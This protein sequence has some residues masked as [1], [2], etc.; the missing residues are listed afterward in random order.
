VGLEALGQGQVLLSG[1]LGSQS[2]YITD[3]LEDQ[4]FFVVV[5]VNT[6]TWL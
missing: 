5:T 4:S 6:Q 1:N 2:G 3:L